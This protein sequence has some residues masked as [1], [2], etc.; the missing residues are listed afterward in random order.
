MIENRHS[1]E[2]V[3]GFA[4]RDAAIAERDRRNKRAPKPAAPEQLVSAARARKHLRHLQ[5]LGVGSKSVHAACGIAYSVLQRLRTGTIKRTRRATETKILA[6]DGTA[7]RGTSKIDGRETWQM[8]DALIGSQLYKKAWIAKQLGS[9]TPALQMYNRDRVRADKAIAVKAL[10]DRLWET[11]A[12]LREYVDPA[13]ERERVEAAQ[14]AA[15]T[16]A[17]RE[18]LARA[19]SGWDTDEFAMRI[20]RFAD[21]PKKGLG[22]AS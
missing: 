22:V 15:A 1:G 8:L 21:M 5:Q 17:S 2:I 7:A 6:V 14:L 11:D 20:S 16:N 9:N 19:L 3:R 12:R 13:G 4:D 10:Y 18:K